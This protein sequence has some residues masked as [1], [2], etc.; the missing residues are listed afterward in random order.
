ML[1]ALAAMPAEGAITLLVD[2]NAKTFTWSGTATSNSFVVAY[3]GFQNL[4]LGMGSW[5]G[6]TSTENGNGGISTT[7]NVVSGSSTSLLEG[8]NPGQFVMASTQDSLYT[9]LGF[10][11]KTFSSGFPG[12]ETATVS[13]TITGNGQTY[14]YASSLAN[15]QA[16]LESLDGADLY[17]QSYTGPVPLNLGSAAGEIVVVPEPSSA[18]LA[19]AAPLALLRRRRGT[20]A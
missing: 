19:L 2:T 18:L 14:S 10:V 8:F 16:F 11:T 20:T 15:E 13:L 1:A 17:F 5:N 9:D 6:G 12:D 3:G 7:L 4:R